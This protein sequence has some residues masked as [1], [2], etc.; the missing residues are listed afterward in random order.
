MSPSDI[1]R[2]HLGN[3]SRDFA[4]RQV[5]ALPDGREGGGFPTETSGAKGQGQ[6]Q[7]QACPQGS[8]P[9]TLPR[10]SPS[11]GGANRG[12]GQHSP[13]LTPC[14]LGAFPEPNRILWK[15]IWLLGA[16]CSAG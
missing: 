6:G 13:L 3:R 1:A 8:G 4:S 5:P 9:L 16:L 14:F 2:V 15:R 11:A 12:A 7:G 10:P